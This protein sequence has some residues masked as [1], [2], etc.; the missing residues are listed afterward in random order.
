[1]RGALD[2]ASVRLPQSVV[3]LASVLSANPLLR[4]LI[5]NT[6][7]LFQ[8]SY[9]WGKNEVCTVNAVKV[10]STRQSK[11]EQVFQILIEKPN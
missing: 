7:I 5:R 1:M 6:I 9:N 4:R 10:V 2:T 11:A 3:L 8:N